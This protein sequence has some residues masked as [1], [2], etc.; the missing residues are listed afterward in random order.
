MESKKIL[1]IYYRLFKAGGLTKVLVNL[2]NELANSGYDVTILIMLNDKST[3]YY[4]DERVKIEIV[5]S[6]ST[7][8]FQKINVNINKHLPKFSYKNEVKNYIYDL[9]QWRVLYNWLKNNHKNYDVIIS[10]YYKISAQLCLNKKVNYKTIAWEHNS[11]F[12]GGFLW[13]KMLRK[14]Y[15]NLKGVVCINEPGYLKYKENNN[16][17]YLIRNI[18][19]E[20]Y[21]KL[22]FQSFENKFNQIIL[23]G[24]L[25]AQKNISEFLDI[26]SQINFD[27]WHVKIIGTGPQY[28]M[29]KYKIDQLDLN[30]VVELVGQKTES[31][32]INYQLES[33]IVCLTSIEEGFGM[34][35][36]EG[37]FTSNV[38]VSY[39]C[40]YGPSDIVNE[41][42]G[43]LIPMHDKQLFKEKL[44]YL[45]DNPQ[46][47]ENLCKSSYEQSKKWKK[48][49]ILNQ[50]ITILK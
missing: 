22:S 9:G 33:K 25:D 50:W 34:V 2:C 49:K 11:Y 38:L 10:S 23:V 17:T 7:F 16:N 28:N 13:F 24:R 30:K 12:H 35:L 3:F 41:K 21:E 20:S 8:E 48:E 44:Q 45:I 27:D 46:E 37:V 15:K 1:F 26:L 18:I 40:N 47:L 43:F 4:L 31:E 5:D 19:G 29:L 39:D 42:N 36:V 32:V 6:F 14:Y